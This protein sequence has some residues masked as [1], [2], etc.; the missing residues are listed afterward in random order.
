MQHKQ[1]Y[2]P[3]IIVPFYA[4]CRRLSIGD[5]LRWLKMGWQDFKRTPWHSL[6]YGLVFVFLG[7]LLLYLAW[8]HTNN[9]FIVSLLFSFVIMGPV[10]CFGLYDTSHQLEKNRKPTFRHQREKAFHEIRYKRLFAMMVSNLLVCLIITL[11]IMVGME[12]GIGKDTGFHALVFVLIALI[13][14]GL[15]FCASAFAL[16]MIL[17]QDADGASAILTSINAVLRNKRVLAFWA[18]LIFILTAVG[19]VAALIGLAIT[20]PVLG[21]AAWH[22]YRETIITNE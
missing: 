17:H 1:K 14:A 21:Y 20:T 3:G 16:P 6:G 22:A 19:F 7:W 2:Q 10:L 18:L 15:A 9:A 8:I 12:S 13:F 5:P 11:S 4:P